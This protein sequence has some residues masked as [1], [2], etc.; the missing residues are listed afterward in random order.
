[1]MTVKG[2]ED[3]TSPSLEF[4]LASQ[5][6]CVGCGHDLD[7]EGSVNLHQALYESINYILVSKTSTRVQGE[8]MDTGKLHIFKH[9]LPASDARAS[10]SLFPLSASDFCSLFRHPDVA[11]HEPPLSHKPSYKE[12]AS[13]SS[14]NGSRHIYCAVFVAHK[15][16]WRCG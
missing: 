16:S 9:G 1:M 5:P 10:S 13:N 4:S 7:G 8:S 11:V 6:A 12:D 15:E 14:H 3:V 2:Y